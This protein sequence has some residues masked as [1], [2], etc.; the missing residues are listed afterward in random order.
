MAVP[1]ALLL[2][3]RNP[4]FLF[5]LRFDFVV[6]FFFT[7]TPFYYSYLDFWINDYNI[8]LFEVK[9]IIDIPQALP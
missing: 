8:T 7:K 2:L 1:A 3:L 6:R 4:C 5:L 9:R